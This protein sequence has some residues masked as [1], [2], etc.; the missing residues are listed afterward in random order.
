MK[1]SEPGMQEPL[2]RVS[3]LAASYGSVQVLS[4][5]TLNVWSRS[6][7]ALLGANGAGKTTL[8]RSVCGMAQASGR[9]TLNKRDLLGL[10][11]A[12]I[13]RSGIAHV[14]EGRGTF[15]DLSVEDNLRVGGFARRDGRA[16]RQD[17]E[18]IYQWLPRLA[19]RRMQQAGSLSGGEQQML[20]IGRAL[21]ARPTVLLLDEPSFGLAPR[22]VDE[23]F[24]V[25]QELRDRENLGVLL[26]EQNAARALEVSDT[27]Y[28][29]RD[30]TIQRSGP[31]ALLASDPSVIEA[32]LGEH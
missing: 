5:I 7:T 12:Q 27:A 31:A 18:Q 23:I 3:G 10:T 21:M 17:L 20:A 1:P 30:G 2:L 8:L 11:T 22:M 28:L 4:D 29:L 32:Y 14:P 9:V 26:V 16:S 19:E 15:I 13:A 6:I 24:R 25:L